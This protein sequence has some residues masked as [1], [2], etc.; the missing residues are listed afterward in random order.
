MKFC[1]GIIT[2]ALRFVAFFT[3]PLFSDP[4]WYASGGTTIYALVEPSIYM[5]ASILPTTRHLYRRIR[6]KAQSLSSSSQPKSKNSNPSDSSAARS[7]NVDNKRNV[8]F[9]IRRDVDVWQTTRTNSSQ[10]GLTLG[11]F[12]AREQEVEWNQMNDLEGAGKK[13]EERKSVS[14]VVKKPV[15]I[16]DKDGVRPIE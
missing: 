14:G 5:I 3:T 16:R 4:T 2:C 12:Y 11:E 15:R 9:G 6:R 13:E 10:E 1:R 8:T 7:D